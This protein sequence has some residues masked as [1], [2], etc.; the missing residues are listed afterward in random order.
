MSAR[1]YGSSCDV[2]HGRKLFDRQGYLIVPRLI[3]QPLARFLFS[4]VDAKV[5]CMLVD[6]G[7]P[8][9]PNSPTGYGDFAFDGLLE[10]LRPQI[11]C[12]CGLALYPTYSYF[13]LYKRGD[14]LKRHRD[15]SACEISI[16]L[17][18]GQTPADPWPLHIE[19]S[20]GSYGALLGPGDALLYRGMERFHWREAYAGARLAQVFLHYIDRNG[21]HAEQKFDG[22]KSLMRPKSS[23][24]D[25]NRHASA[26]T[27][28]QP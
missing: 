24:V 6:A 11:E 5:A 25:Q 9:V 18:L 23:S 22:R 3:A 4:Y 16:S 1:A 7:D 21:P 20:D 28:T 2:D 12:W 15:R 17:N 10:Y 14:I 8:Q 27:V 13:R 26:A 19:N